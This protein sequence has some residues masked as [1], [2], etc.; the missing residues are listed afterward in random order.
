MITGNSLEYVG[1]MLFGSVPASYTVVSSTEIIAISPAESAGTATAEAKN[2]ALIPSRAEFTYSSRSGKGPAERHNERCCFAPVR[3]VP[4]CQSGG[5]PAE[6][7]AGTAVAAG[8]WCRRWLRAPPVA[9]LFEAGSMDG[10]FSV[11]RAAGRSAT[12]GRLCRNRRGTRPGRRPAA[13]GKRAGAAVGGRAGP[14][15]RTGPRS[16]VG[17]EPGPIAVLD[18]LGSHRAG[19]VPRARRPRHR[20]ECLPRT[21]VAGPH[22]RKR[23]R[24]SARL[25]WRPGDRAR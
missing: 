6:D 3:A 2:P 22:R 18:R 16:P 25:P 19:A 4:C 20:L 7:A 12:A 15:C 23:P 8:H 1:E 11:S 24:P 13:G 14:P 10:R 9:E 5:G 17:A 21:P